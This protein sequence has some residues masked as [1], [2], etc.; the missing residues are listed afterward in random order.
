MNSK[1]AAIADSPNLDGSHDVTIDNNGE[2]IAVN[3]SLQHVQELVAKFQARIFEKQL[4]IPQLAV[5]RID[6]I[7]K[8]ATCE[9][10]VSTVQ[11]GTVVLAMR[12]AELRQMKKEIDR[13]LAYRCSSTGQKIKF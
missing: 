2:R 4:Q 1:L 8:E 12:D 6:V 7:R 13:V 3:I 10:M 11:T 5:H 9:L